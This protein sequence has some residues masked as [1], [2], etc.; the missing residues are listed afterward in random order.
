MFL[1]DVSVGHVGFLTGESW[2]EQHRRGTRSVRQ[3]DIGAR[4]CTSDD[5]TTSLQRVQ[6][7]ARKSG[8]CSWAIGAARSR[9]REPVQRPLAQEVISGGK[10]HTF[11]LS[12][13]KNELI[14]QV[15]RQ[16]LVSLRQKESSTPKPGRNNRESGINGKTRK[17]LHSCTRRPKTFHFVCSRK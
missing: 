16:R 9:S 4:V 1:L 2:L 8:A 5:K 3:H 11:R 17:S 14:E 10:E 12:E 13:E 15:V 6:A 7:P